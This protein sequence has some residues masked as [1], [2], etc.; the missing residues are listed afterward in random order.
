MLNKNLQKL[1]NVD[2][3]VNAPQ[4]EKVNLMNIEKICGLE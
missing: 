3:E 4:E 2:E 1:E